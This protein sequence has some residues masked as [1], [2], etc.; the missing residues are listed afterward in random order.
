MARL[1]KTGNGDRAVLV[2]ATDQRRLGFILQLRDLT[3]HEL[4]RTLSRVNV[5]LIQAGRRFALP[6]VH[7]LNN[8][9]VLATF[10]QRPNWNAIDRR[11]RSES[12]VAARDAHEARA[13]LID[14]ETCTK[15]IVA[16]I[17][18]DIDRERRGA[19]NGLQLLRLGAEYSRIFPQHSD[20][21]WDQRRR[22]R[23]HYTNVDPRPRRPGRKGFLKGADKFV[24]V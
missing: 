18:A 11:I 3:Q 8:R 23:L 12:D 2:H 10:A 7:H 9:N 6:I 5:K 4:V 19:E 24:R 16:P 14:L 1:G 17:V 13:I 20:R 22:P 15:R 21:Q